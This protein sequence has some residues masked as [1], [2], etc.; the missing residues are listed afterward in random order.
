MI[1]SVRLRGKVQTV[2]VRS[3]RVEQVGPRDVF[4]EGRDHTDTIVL[5][6]HM[7]PTDARALIRGLQA[8]LAKGHRKGDTQPR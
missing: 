1:V 6:A 5:A 4:V 3:I 2:G 8:A 7:E